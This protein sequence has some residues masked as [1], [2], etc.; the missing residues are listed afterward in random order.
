MK[1]E[2][3]AYEETLRAIAEEP[4]GIAYLRSDKKLRESII[5]NFTTAK[6][7][8]MW[9]FRRSIEKWYDDTL[10]LLSKGL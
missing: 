3:E 4:G 9:P 5:S 8:W 1:F 7:I 6:Y 10:T 2:R